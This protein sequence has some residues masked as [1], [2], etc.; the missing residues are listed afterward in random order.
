MEAEITDLSGVKALTTLSRSSIYALVKIGR[1][2]KPCR[3]AGT[4]RT[5]WRVADIRAWIATNTEAT[6]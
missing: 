3:I 4:T 5:V 2:P 1:F 6:S